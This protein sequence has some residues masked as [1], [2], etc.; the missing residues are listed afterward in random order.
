MVFKFE[1]LIP[2]AAINITTPTV[3]SPLHVACSEN[4]PNRLEVLQ[5]LLEKGADPNIVVRSESGRPL[6]PPLGEYLVNAVDHDV[7]VI[8]LLLKFGAQVLQVLSKRL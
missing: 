5:L 1:A 3:G 8:K 6:R 2:D 7:E 4:I